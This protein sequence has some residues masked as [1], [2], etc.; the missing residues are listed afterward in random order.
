LQIPFAKFI[1]VVKKSVVKGQKS[2][3]RSF[4][5]QHLADGNSDNHPWLKR[6]KPL[7]PLPN[8]KITF[9]SSLSSKKTPKSVIFLCWGA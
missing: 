4:H 5:P 1:Y 8:L 9:L 3:R 6:Q 7:L 2:K